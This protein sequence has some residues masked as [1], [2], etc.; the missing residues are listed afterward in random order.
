MRDKAGVGGDL[1]GCA[2]VS[3]DDGTLRPS[4][5]TTDSLLVLNQCLLYSVHPAPLEDGVDEVSGRTHC[6]GRVGRLLH[7][8]VGI[9]GLRGSQ[10]S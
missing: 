1:S 10:P 8:Q 2:G 6:S 7:P 9:G 4:T 3:G 5:I